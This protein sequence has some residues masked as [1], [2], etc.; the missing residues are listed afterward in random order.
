MGMVRRPVRENAGKV[1]IQ[2]GSVTVRSA[3]HHRGRGV[4]ARGQP[5]QP[6]DGHRETQR[7]HAE[8]APCHRAPPEGLLGQHHHRQA[9]HGPDVHHAHRDQNHH[10][11]P[12]TAEAVCPVPDAGGQVA[13]PP[14]AP[15]Q[16]ERRTAMRQAAVLGAAQLV[17]AAGREDRDGQDVR[18][19]GMPPGQP[20]GQPGEPER[21]HARRSPD[22]EVAGREAGGPSCPAAGPAPGVARGRRRHRRQHHGGH[23]QRPYRHERSQAEPHGAAHP[24]HPAS[25]EHGSGPRAGRYEQQRA[26]LH[27]SLT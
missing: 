15:G 14:A 25:Q 16:R 12:A 24:G 17:H 1:A 4:Q 19:A 2:P 6:D 13:G 7:G 22:R 18:R 23:H 10:Q 20:A 3:H 27:R 26:R 11:P 21:G 8:R 5:G 9:D